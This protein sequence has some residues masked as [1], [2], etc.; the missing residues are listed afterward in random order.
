[1]NISQAARRSGLSAKTIRYYEQIGLVT[2]AGRA[3]N[4]YRQYDDTD[5]EELRFLSRARQ[6]GFD[7]EECRQLLELLRDHGRHSAHARELVLEKARE[8]RAQIRELRAMEVQLADMA[9][10]CNGDEGPE[11]AIL[12]DLARA[13]R[14]GE[15]AG[16]RAAEKAAEKA[17][18]RAVDG[19]GDG[20]DDSTGDSARKGGRHHV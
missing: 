16:E 12:D 17:A 11:C 5:L 20:T 1:M 4:G 18:E 3:A 8:V 10:R 14:A 9:R 2:A 19:A 7:L 13:A 15:R 6:V